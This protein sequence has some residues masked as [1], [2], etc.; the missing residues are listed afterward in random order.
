MEEAFASSLDQVM[1]NMIDTTPYGAFVKRFKGHSSSTSLE[2]FKDKIC[3]VLCGGIVQNA[4]VMPS[5]LWSSVLF[6][7]HLAK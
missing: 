6:C 5:L 1:T 3:A 2:K 4:Y 7:E